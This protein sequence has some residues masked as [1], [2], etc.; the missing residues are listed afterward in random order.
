MRKEVVRGLGSGFIQVPF[1]P[2]IVRAAFQILESCGVADT[3]GIQSIQLMSEVKLSCYG[4]L[5]RTLTIWSLAD[6]LHSNLRTLKNPGTTT[7][8]EKTH[9]SCHI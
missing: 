6:G 3:S 2:I 4:V 5:V 1:Q 8:K 9:S 7:C